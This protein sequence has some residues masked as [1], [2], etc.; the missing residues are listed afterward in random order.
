LGPRHLS[1][2]LLH[3]LGETDDGAAEEEWKEEEEAAAAAAAAGRISLSTENGR[4]GVN[5]DAGSWPAGGGERSVAHGWSLAGAG[6]AEAS[7]WL[8]AGSVRMAC[9]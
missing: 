5:M 6:K 1:S 8:R 2:V 7:S 3:T 9:C 4:I